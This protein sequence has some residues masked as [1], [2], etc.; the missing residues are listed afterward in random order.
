MDDLFTTFHT[1]HQARNGYTLAQTLLPTFAPRLRALTS[2]TTPTSFPTDLRYKTIY[3]PAFPAT[4][5]SETTAWLDVYTAYYRCVFALVA[6]EELTANGRGAEAR[7]VGVYE[8]WKET[9]NALIKGYAAGHFAAWTVPCLYVGGKWARVLAMRA[10]EAVA[11][12]G[13]KIGGYEDEDVWAGEGEAAGKHDNLEDAARLINR[14]FSLCI[15]DRYVFPK[16]SPAAS[17]TGPVHRYRRPRLTNPPSNR[18][19]IEDSRKWALYNITNLLF[20]TY[21][22]LNSLSLC[23]T[24]LRSLRASTTDMPPLSSFPKSHVVTFNYYVGILHFLSEDYPAAEEALTSS[25]RLCPRP[26]SGNGARAAG[27]AS[28]KVADRNRE[29]ILTYLIP[30]RLLTVRQLPSHGL[31]APYPRL[32]GLFAPLVACLK[33]GDLAGFDAALEEGAGVFV[34]KRV[35][36]TLERGREL[37][38]RNLFRKVFLA[39]GWE[40]V[41]GKRV[42]RTRVPVE[43]FRVALNLG[44]GT[45]GGGDQV[46]DGGVGEEVGID[47]D[48][49][50]CWVANCVCKASEERAAR[51]N[52]FEAIIDSVAVKAGTGNAPCVRISRQMQDRDEEDEDKNSEEAESDHDT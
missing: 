10:D 42:R 20:A 37:A 12:Y 7:W 44:S 21:F 18:A 6:A 50:E 33:R 17:P 36:L 13:G 11:R 30:T 48:E 35:Y 16:S 29:R 19:P 34:R 32:Q 22:R 28:S 47:R 5:K 51:H 14:I 15:G 25:L 1:A 38:V 8:A 26:S 49:A 43:E 27:G 40:E 2:S 52:W 9:V 23:K 41:G 39:G 24:I 4:S 3:D 31:L 45:R 46:M